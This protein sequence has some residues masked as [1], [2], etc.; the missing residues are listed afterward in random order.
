MKKEIKKKTGKEEEGKKKNKRIYTIRLFIYQNSLSVSIVVVCS[1]GGGT[2]EQAQ[3]II[4]DK[5]SQTYREIA[6]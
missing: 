6:L 4:I 1:S 3:Q 5:L 2:I